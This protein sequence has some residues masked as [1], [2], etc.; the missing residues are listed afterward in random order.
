MMFEYTTSP[1]YKRQQIFIWWHWFP[2]CRIRCVLDGYSTARANRAQ[3]I[4]LG[5]GIKQRIKHL[6]GRVERIKVHLFMHSAKQYRQYWNPDSDHEKT[7]ESWYREQIGDRK[8]TGKIISSVP[9]HEKCLIVDFTGVR[10]GHWRVWD[11][12]LGVDTS[13]TIARCFLVWCKWNA[14]EAFC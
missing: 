8:R 1:P 5:M 13:I 4:R 2:L 9:H 12:K 3:A 10:L 14:G 11:V 6:H 7:L